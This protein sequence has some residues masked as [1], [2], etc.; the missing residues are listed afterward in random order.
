MKLA[1]VGNP[2]AH[3]K[4]PLIFRFFFDAVNLEYSYERTALES[5]NEILELFDSGYAGLNITAPF[6]QS[7]IPFLNEL[8]TEAKLIGSVNTVVCRDGKLL[9]YNTDYLGVLNALEENGLKLDSKKCLILGAGGAARAAIFGLKKRNTKIQVYNR[10]KNKA[11]HL[12]KEFDIDFLGDDDLRKAVKDADVLID[13]LPAGVNII[14]Q[15]YLHSGLTILDASYPKSVYE[16]EQI[17]Q[18][19]GGEHWLFHQA[20]PAFELFTGIKLN[21]NEYD[22][23]TILNFLIKT[24]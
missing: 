14:K 16:G 12:A 13:T 23:K 17:K 24:K 20:I 8:S 2:I 6:K 7:V 10:S 11:R 18:L 21:M 1:V 19:I 4:S 15:E 9:G 5:A 3:S 22:R